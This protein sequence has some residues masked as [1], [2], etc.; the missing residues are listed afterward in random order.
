MT[1]PPPYDLDALEQYAPL[2]KVP[3]MP[4]EPEARR[5]WATALALDAAIWGLPAAL[6]Y[7]EMYTQCCDTTSSRHTGFNTFDHQRVPADPTFDAF[8]VPTVD[9]LYSNAFLDLTAGP[10]ALVIPPMGDRYYTLNFQDAY[11]NASNLSSRTVGTGG[12]SFLITSPADWD[13]SNN[14]EQQIFKVASR[15]MWILMRISRRT[16]EEDWSTV[17][18]LQDRVL[19]RT[20]SVPRG[21]DEFVAA[22]PLTIR[23]NAGMFF[24]ALDQV[25]ADNGV[26]I[27]EI[28]L[29]HRY[30]SLGGL[31]TG[32]FD[33]GDLDEPLTEG[34]EEGFSRALGI[35]EA[36]RGRTGIPIEGTGWTSSDPGRSGHDILGRAVANYVG[37]GGN[38]A[39][40]NKPFVAFVDDHGELLDG[41]HKSY[42]WHCSERPPGDDLWSMT[43]YVTATGQV[44]DHS[45]R[46]YKVGSGV[47]GCGAAP[48]GSWTVV[49]SNTEPEDPTNWLPAPPERFFVI[50][51]TWQPGTEV[52][53]GTWTPE[54]INQRS[55]EF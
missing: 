10:I 14:A 44:Y 40:E 7:A 50:I 53:D 18:D 8:K 47:D 1:P 28:G 15:F 37:L 51:R 13:H 36:S 23:S 45:L 11:A 46:R 17:H 54:P 6:Q 12:G 41:S 5:D 22:D 27:S 48:D 35:V 55:P 33:I 26:P 49:I 34:I 31:G 52:L 30:R 39:V 42:T 21:P 43:L 19:L 38:V 2:A 3:A 20:D 9:V 4:L 32:T 16:D 25:I 24:R 29:T